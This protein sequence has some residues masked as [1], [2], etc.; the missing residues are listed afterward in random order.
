MVFGKLKAPDIVTMS[1]GFHDPTRTS[2]WETSAD[3]R[4]D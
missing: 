4:W 2:L 3:G 1:G